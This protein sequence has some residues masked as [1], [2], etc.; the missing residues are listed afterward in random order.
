MS[1]FKRIETVD[2]TILTKITEAE[3][4]QWLAA[5]LNQIRETLPAAS[6]LGVDVHYFQFCRDEHLSASWG[7]HAADKCSGTSPDT[8]TALRTVRDELLN[9]PQR[10]AAEARR[11]AKDLMEEAAQLEALAS[12]SN[13]GT[14]RR[15]PPPQ[16]NDNKQTANGG[17]RSLQ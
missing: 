15:L 6:S 8:A 12:G 17:S 3:V 7:I 4:L 16:S 11:K 13:A 1:D 10:R 2:Q 14:E 5:R 9:N